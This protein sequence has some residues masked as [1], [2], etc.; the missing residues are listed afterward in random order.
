MKLTKL[1]KERG[2]K[3]VEAPY[4]MF[5]KRK[6]LSGLDMQYPTKNTGILKNGE[7]VSITMHNE[8]F[9]NNPKEMVCENGDR[10]I[11]VSAFMPLEWNFSKPS[12]LN[13]PTI[14]ILLTPLVF[15]FIAIYSIFWIPIM[16]KDLFTA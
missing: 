11:S 6:Q 7:K 2:F 16:I 8:D 1:E 14:R 12:Y 3:V 10:Y 5:G 15:L 13:T 9:P 4:T